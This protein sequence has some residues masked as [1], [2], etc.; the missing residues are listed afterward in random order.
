MNNTSDCVRCNACNDLK[1]CFVCNDLFCENCYKTCIN[2]EHCENVVCERCDQED[3]YHDILKCF[4]C[5]NVLCDSCIDSL[6]KKKINV[7]IVIGY[8][9][10]NV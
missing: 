8:S 1:E 10:M 2:Y 6:N 3:L 5:E 9:V 4:N 7:H